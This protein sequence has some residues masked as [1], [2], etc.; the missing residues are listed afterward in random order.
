M[1][2]VIDRKK[3]FDG[4]REL[5][6]KFDQPQVDGIN[7]ICDEFERRQWNDR[8]HLAY[9]FATVQHETAATMQPIEEIGR[10]RG[11]KYGIPDA[12]TGK[13][14][15]G[16]GYVQLTWKRNYVFASTELGVDFV[17][18]PDWVM[19]LEYAL[20][21]LFDGMG[22]GWFA[23][24]KGGTYNLTWFFNEN[25]NDPVEARRIIN[26][27]D[28]AAKIAAKYEKWLKALGG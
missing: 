21:I 26:G 1:G 25:A 12:K 23:G 28:K 9:I 13:T 17:T 11:K 6:G 14:Y 15:Y 10:G 5:F 18:N 19:K 24:A 7:A 27:M 20:D 3:L 2:I 4:A 8:R 16:R 22:E